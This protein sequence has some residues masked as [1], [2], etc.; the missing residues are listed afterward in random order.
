MKKINDYTIIGKI[1]NT[2][3][4]RGDLKVFPMTSV[5]KRFSDLDYVFLGE[6]LDKYEIAKVSYD[7]KFVY[8]TFKGFED[9]NKVLK[10]KEQ[11][12]YIE[13]QNRIKLDKDTFFISDLISCKVY[14]T[15][16]N[17][18]GELI[19]VMEV[20]ANDVY[21]IRGKDN[22]EILIPAVKKFIKSVDVSEK[23][24]V[25]DPIEGMLNEI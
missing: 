23:I 24:I 17:F 9:I 7:N 8:L 21:V 25:I 10:L 19:D 1:I 15:E 14:D 16:N 22:N 2:R 13:D 5:I 3:G 20:P 11:F 18:I 12:I 6:Q 4:I